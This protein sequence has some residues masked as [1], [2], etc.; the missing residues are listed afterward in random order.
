[1]KIHQLGPSCCVKT[2]I[3]DEANNGFSQFANQPKNINPYN[4]GIQVFRAQ[5]LELLHCGVQKN[6]QSVC[7]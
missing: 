3:H 7:G 5:G 1:M 4:E 6:V 2:D